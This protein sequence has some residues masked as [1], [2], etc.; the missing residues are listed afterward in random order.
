MA[1]TS[2]TRKSI[3]GEIDEI[4]KQVSRKISELRR[5]RGFT[6]VDL[7]EKIGVA[8]QQIAKY[9]SGENR[10]TAGRLF[11]LSR[12]FEVSTD[13]FFRQHGFAEENA[14]PVYK[15]QFDI[16]KDFGKIKSQRKRD[17]IK[18]LVAEMARE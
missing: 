4:E 3:V 6:R 18:L 10:I 5:L 14:A 15:D 1:K 13:Y 7:G 12:I 9:E 16:A 2:S 11:A 17:I 8:H